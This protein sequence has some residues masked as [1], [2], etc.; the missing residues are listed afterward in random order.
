MTSTTPISV[1]A[2]ERD[3]FYAAAVAGLRALDRR[4]STARRFG[5]DADTRVEPKGKSDDL[6]GVLQPETGE[7]TMFV[8]ARWRIRRLV[9]IKQTLREME[10]PSTRNADLLGISG[11]DFSKMTRGLFDQKP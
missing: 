1:A 8:R 9:D 4:D 10:V 2:E 7:D 6:P 11:P 3:L 5:P